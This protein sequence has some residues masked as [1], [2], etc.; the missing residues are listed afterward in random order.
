MKVSILGTG[1]IAHSMARTI[2]AVEK[3]E[4]YAVASRSLDSAQEFAKE[5]DIPAA[6]G[7]YDELIDDPKIELVYIA[8]IHPLHYE[9]SKKLLE[10]GKS[11]LC[12]K[13]F[14]MNRAQAEDLFKI[15]K[16]NNAFICEAVWTRF[17]PWVSDVQELINSGELGSP[18]LLDAKFGFKSSSPRLNELKLGGGAMFDMGIYNIT[19]A[20][21]LFGDD[22]DIA[23]TS[24]ILSD[25]GV[26]LHNFTM[27]K[28]PDGKCAYLTSSIDMSLNSRITVYCE[29]GYIEII[30]P[31]N[32]KTVN[33]FDGKKNLIRE[34]KP[35]VIT[36]YTFELE[37]C[38]EAI[39][40]GKSECAE[41]THD[42]T[43]FVMGVM[44]ELLSRWG[45]KYPN[46]GI[47]D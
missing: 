1:N 39:E 32:W 2:Q 37:A 43:L 31:S 33:V 9:L 25:N 3:A 16:E 12:E 44:D 15:A 38:I 17:F 8:T 34:I 21:L 27:L 24:C 5:F 41:I 13:P 4:F 6:Y 28:Y 35:D 7:S 19:A 47:M 26:D 20:D 29:N 14:A 18:K 30:G 45:M 23:D 36:G 11:V 22:F 42:K 40:K 10:K 46:V